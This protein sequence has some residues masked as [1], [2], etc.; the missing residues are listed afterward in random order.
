MRLEMDVI[1]VQATFAHIFDR[2]FP[3][4]A[5]VLNSGVC[6]RAWMGLEGH[7]SPIRG[8]YGGSKVTHGYCKM[9]KCLSQTARLNPVYMLN[10]L[11]FSTFRTGSFP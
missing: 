1:V 10:G 7:G 6:T 9:L 2:T 4:K 11:S 5:L 8:G 3:R